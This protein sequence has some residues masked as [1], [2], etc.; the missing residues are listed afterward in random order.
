MG[1]MFDN[2]HDQMKNWRWDNPRAF[3]DQVDC[4]NPQT[5]S[6]G[7]VKPTCERFCWYSSND[8]S[9]KI[10]PPSCRQFKRADLPALTQLK[11]D[12]GIEKDD[13]D[14]EWGHPAAPG[15]GRSRPGGDSDNDDGEGEQDTQGGDTGTRTGK[16]T[17]DRKGKGKEK[18]KVNGKGKGIV[19]LN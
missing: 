15:S 17:K 9:A 12:E 7:K 3:K 16:G 11:W 18:G 19:K 2:T 1:Q 5:T 14:E 8:H 10:E 4:T 6:L 13:D